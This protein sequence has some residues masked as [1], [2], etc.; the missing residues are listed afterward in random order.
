[1]REEMAIKFYYRRIF[2]MTV[3]PFVKASSKSQL[4]ISFSSLVFETGFATGID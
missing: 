2:N 1:M 3:N 4:D